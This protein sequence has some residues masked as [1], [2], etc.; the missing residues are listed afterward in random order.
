MPFLADH[1]SATVRMISL[2]S[3][4]PVNLFSLG[5]LLHFHSTPY[6]DP[7]SPPSKPVYFLILLQLSEILALQ[8]AAI[9]A[10]RIRLW[11]TGSFALIS[12]S[13]MLYFWINTP[14]KG[15]HKATYS[16]SPLLIVCLV[17]QRMPLSCQLSSRSGAYYRKPFSSAAVYLR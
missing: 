2:A 9:P 11:V 13:S 1:S 17:L 12:R 8:I 10:W 16:I 5:L 6:N 14:D 15:I 3:I 7:M 4:T